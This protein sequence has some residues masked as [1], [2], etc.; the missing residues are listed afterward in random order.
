MKYQLCSRCQGHGVIVHPALSV[1][2][3]EDRDRDPDGIE[4]MMEG[5]YDVVCPLCKGRRVTTDEGERQY[6][7]RLADA[8]VAAY[9]SG[10]YEA[11]STGIYE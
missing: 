8:R 3:E 2:T 4:G 10:D 6:A 11:I 7:D 5:N 1:W 9:E